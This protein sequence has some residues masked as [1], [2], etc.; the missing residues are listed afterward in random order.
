MRIYIDDDTASAALANL[1][2]NAGH[3]VRVP[4]D[5]GMGAAMTRCTLRT[6]SNRAAF[7]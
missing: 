5:A 2:R 6:L 4:A 1:L 7:A 3:D